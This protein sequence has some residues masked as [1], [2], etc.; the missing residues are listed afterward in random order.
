[1]GELIRREAAA[2]PLAFS[3]ERLTAAIS[4][5]VEI[6]HYHRYLLAREFCRGHDVLDVAAG[7][8]YGTALLA[9]VARSAV[10]VEID[11][12]AVEAARAEFV[13]PNL[14]FELGDAR[15]L[16][17][18]DASV[19]V[20]VTFETLEHLAEQDVFL[21]E[22]RRV[23]RPGGLLIISTP[24]RDAYSPAGAPPNPYHVLELTQSEF[25]A[26]LGRHFARSAVAGQRALIGSVILG[27]GED[28]PV[29]S[30]ERRSE[31]VIE[32][33]ERLSRAPYLLAFASDAPLPPLPNSVYIYRAD[34]D[35]DP[36]V[37]QEAELAR[38][39][40]EGATA[41]AIAR[42]EVAESH[43][44]AAEQQ[45][46][47][48]VA[49][50][51]EGTE[52]E[53]NAARMIAGLQQSSKEL[54]AAAEQA[55]VA[56]AAELRRVSEAAAMELQHAGTLAAVRLARLQ[57]RLELAEQRA[58][59]AELEVD[60]LG[61]LGL[62][63]QS[64]AARAEERAER[65]ER[66]TAETTHRLATEMTGHFEAQQ[67]AHLAEQRLA[68]IEASSVWRTTRP[69]RRVGGRFPLLARGLRRGAKLAWWTGT[70]QVHRRYRVWRTVRRQQPQVQLQPQPAPVLHPATLHLSPPELPAELPVLLPPA[71]RPHD[72]RIPSSR[73][74]DVS[75]IIST[76]GQL[77]VT[78]ACLKSIADHAPRCSLEVIVVDDA[79]PG[80]EDM[81]ALRDVA[82]IQLVRNA[83]N[84]GFLRS[85]NQAARA[86]KGRY[87]YMLNNDTEL[88]PGAIDALADLLDSRPDAAM[89]GSKL[90]FPDGRL[91]EAGGILWDD[92]S[93][94]NYGRGED[95][96]RPEYSYVREVDYCSGASIMVRRPAF[97]SVGGFDE[98]FA[99]AYYEDADLAFRLRA[100]KLRVLYEPRSVV[101][102]HEGMS[103][104]TDLASGVKAHQVA[105][106][107][108]MAE[109]WGATLAR[110][111]YPSGQHVLRARDRARTRKVI[112]VIDHYAPEPDRDAGSR[113]AMGII[114]SLLAAGW[115]VKFWP[116]NRLYSPVYTTALE[117]RGIEVLDQR[118]PG[119][120]DA[121]MR[122]NGG[123]LDH[124]LVI[125]PDVAV[126]AL[127]HLMRN[128]D[129]VLS[130]YGVDL[131]FARMRRQASLDPSPKLLQDAAAMERLE[132]RIWRHFDVVI[133][134]SEEEAAVVRAMA[135]N[136]LARGIVPF[137]FDAFPPRTAPVAGHSILFVAGFAH[138]PN[139]D[140]AMFL[141]QEVIPQLEGEVGPVKVTL[142]GSNPTKAVRALAGLDVEVTGY[143]TDEELSAL[144]DRH[145]VSVVPLRFGA[146]VKGKVVESLSRGLPL[147][148]TSVGAQG[149][150]GLG[151]VVPVHDD[152]AGIVAALR[153]LLTDDAAWMAQSAAQ[154]AFAQRWFSRAAMRR[155]VLSAFEAGEAAR[156]RAPTIK[157]CSG[158]KLAAETL[159]RPSQEAAAPIEIDQTFL[160]LAE[161]KAWASEHRSVADAAA[162]DEI[163][164]RILRTGFIE[165]LTGT[166]ISPAEIEHAGR[167]WREGLTARGLNSRMR[168]VLAL[169]DEKIGA[170]PPDKVQI[171]ATEAVTPFALL[172]RGHFARFHG[173]EYGADA[174][175]RR[176]LYPIPHEDLT[177]LSLPSGR[178]DLVTTNEVLEHVPDLDAALREIARVLK[179]GGWHVGTH[180]F[181]LMAEA[182]DRRSV[183]LDGEVAHLKAPEYHGNPVD[184]DAG[185]LVFE[186]PGWDIIGRAK[187][188]GFRNVHMRFVASE[189]YGYITANIG[190]FVFCAQR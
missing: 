31:T 82:G 168:A 44:A 108:R 7:E 3:G 43:A 186:T 134:P 148:T 79:Y 92:A 5:Q 158:S 140:A 142:A 189:R 81:G 38:L 159:A 188:A 105:N 37:R 106:Q 70:L 28:A 9:Q 88:Q 47:A 61:R 118:W 34:L 77:G 132:R 175:A 113:S 125:R 48:A 162:A 122:E 30:Y 75:V 143:V 62:A 41:L 104:G 40:A 109:R 150:A 141:M 128:T 116:E 137:C 72:I 110:E 80:P 45:V 24:D 123:E 19:D 112:L 6:E 17:L 166:A 120:L 55:S 90:L 91:Q 180:P 185:S 63:L 15:A 161:W 74:P 83:G 121:W 155:S 133:Y 33:S 95:P 126:K 135:P 129:A 139:V 18:P 156:P 157:P 11:E 50:A 57:R 32:G 20:A 54:A 119:D 8:G 71:P 98:D 97:E 1:M 152:V 145:R 130:M 65:A 115:V 12:G 177:T 10:G 60:Q 190:V 165:P 58:A 131:H 117:R 111:N 53:A 29:R 183:L 35:T 174:D 153:R 127:P 100:R 107:A 26:L 136:T 14:R 167:N 16:P 64:Q 49:R 25:K 182:G 89:A 78:L 164:G 85:C 103:H 46:V 66:E 23:L 96:S 160:S 154:M 151:E 94:W 146:G 27:G 144:Y 179:P 73:E 93:G 171:F 124:L 114:D 87:L 68:A 36:R 67:Q 149:I 163:G 101:V 178:F 76:Y 86:A 138:P 84:L 13:R 176:A 52:R 4:G 39:A 21:A 184:R 2:A 170:R 42:A 59:A 187:A 173:A 69:L 147:V 22:L 172:M 102:H 56:A 169:I 51:A 181:F 99:P